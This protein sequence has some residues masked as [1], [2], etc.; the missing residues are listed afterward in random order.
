[1][2]IKMFCFDV[3]SQ[4]FGDLV[5]GLNKCVLNKCV[6]LHLHSSLNHQFRYIKNTNIFQDHIQLYK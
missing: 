2:K 6:H 4:R 1:M 5:R 3:Y